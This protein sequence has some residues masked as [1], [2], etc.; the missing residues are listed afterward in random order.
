[1]PIYEYRC[2]ECGTEFEALVRGG[3]EPTACPSCAAARLERL[4]S[5][6]AV[7]SEGTRQTARARSLPRAKQVQRDKDVAERELFERHRH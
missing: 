6:F 4:I 1:M 7:D 3:V 2:L 5:A